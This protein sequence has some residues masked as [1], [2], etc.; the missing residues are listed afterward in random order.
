[1]LLT[2]LGDNMRIDKESMGRAREL[3]DKK[4]TDLDSWLM[5]EQRNKT[6]DQFLEVV[7]RIKKDPEQY[8][9]LK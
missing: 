4:G 1:M 9:C 6:R 3:Y 2:C 5:V 7:R 8:Q